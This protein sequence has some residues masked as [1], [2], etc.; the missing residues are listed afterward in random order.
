MLNVSA[1]KGDDVKFTCQ[2]EN[3]GK[4]KVA[5]LKLNPPL[6]ISSQRKV[7]LKHQKYKIDGG[8]PDG[9]GV[10]SWTLNLKRV[11]ERDAGRYM[12]QVGV[13]PTLTQT[14]FLNL[15]TPPT[16]LSEKTSNDVVA[17]E[18]SNVTL[19]CEANGEPK[20]DIT[21]KRLDQENIITNDPE[22]YGEKIVYGKTLTL[23]KVN[24][25]HTADYLCLADNGIM[26]TDGWSVKLHVH[27]PPKV[28][29]KERHVVGHPSYDA[30]L[31]CKA[32]AWPRPEFRWHFG[33]H[34]LMVNSSKYQMLLNTQSPLAVY[35]SESILLIRALKD[36]DDFGMY[37]CSA[38]NEYGVSQIA[39]E[40]RKKNFMI[41]RI[42]KIN[43][44]NEIAKMHYEYESLREKNKMTSDKRSFNKQ[45]SRS[46]VGIVN[47][48]YS[49]FGYHRLPYWIFL[50]ISIY[51]ALL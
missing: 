12:C 39:I 32:E 43:D 16:I 1:E 22:G 4:N 6:L 2:I 14:A 17:T 27:F 50:Y 40:I 10:Q 25:Y 38:E 42:K 13:S 26:P 29:S 8:D 5:F 49:I 51:T 33:D 7:Y 18:N 48:Q 37:I 19:T 47:E 9:S 11:D 24:R 34:L 36:D 28:S 23:Y 21:W 3:L 30:K 44:N 15:R 20:P 31:R 41:D 46:N 35:E 45:E